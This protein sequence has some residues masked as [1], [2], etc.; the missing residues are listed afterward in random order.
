MRGKAFDRTYSDCGFSFCI[1]W[2]SLE[3]SHALQEPFTPTI[4]YSFTLL[5]LFS[6]TQASGPKIH[7]FILY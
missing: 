2:G 1:K 6:C 4:R 7:P 5:I 3:H